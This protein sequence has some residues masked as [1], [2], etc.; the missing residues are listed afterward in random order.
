MSISQS[1][2]PARKSSYR[3]IPWVFVAAMGV[4]IVVNGALVYF[5]LG[6]RSAVVGNS[7]YEEGRQYAQILARQN[8]QGGQNWQ[9]AAGYFGDL[10]QG[11]IEI[12]LRDAAGK[13]IDNAQ[14]V[15]RVTRLVGYLPG[16][17]VTLQSQGSGRYANRYIMAAA[18]QWDLLIEV[19]GAGAGF[20]SQK[21]IVVK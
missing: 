11:R 2:Q 17:A 21:R 6:S 9:V 19:A 5:A 1:G 20:S 7:P 18:G 13:P 14:V 10:H 16:E 4:V 15:V 12:E 8:A 3:W